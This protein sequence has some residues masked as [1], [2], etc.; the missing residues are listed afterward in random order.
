MFYNNKKVYFVKDSD[1]GNFIIY[2]FFLITDKYKNR[3]CFK[4]IIRDIMSIRLKG[5][6][7]IF[8]IRTDFSP[9]F[10]AGIVRYLLL[11]G[12]FRKD[13]VFFLFFSFFLSKE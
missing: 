13:V 12:F 3:F 6:T 8:G 2:L 9:S 7:E 11:V 10:R 5:G 1:K 4:L